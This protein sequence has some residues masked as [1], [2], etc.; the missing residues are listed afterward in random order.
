[1][2]KFSHSQYVIPKW[3][4]K[5]SPSQKSHSTFVASKW[6]KNLG[7]PYVPGCDID[8]L[9]DNLVLRCF[10]RAARSES[11]REPTKFEVQPSVHE[12]K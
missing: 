3:Y 1:M 10:A 5:T 9:C 8:D 6:N 11:S 4:D 2:R 12:K 7:R